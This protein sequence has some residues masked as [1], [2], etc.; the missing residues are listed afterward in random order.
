ML[1]TILRLMTYTK[2]IILRI[3]FLS[4]LAFLL[5]PLAWAQDPTQI[6]EWQQLADKNEKDGNLNEAAKYIN[7]LAYGFWDKKQYTQSLEF[8]QKSLEMNEKIG[9]KNSLSAING[10]IGMI[11]SDLKEYK[12]A[13]SYFEKSLDIRKQMKDRTGEVSQL[14]NIGMTLQYLKEY[15]ASNERIENALQLAKEL[16]NTGLMKNCYG[17]LAENYDKLGNTTKSFEY[18]NYFTALEK[19]SQKEE[20][21]KTQEEMNKIKS[22][23]QQSEQL[24]LMEEKALDEQNKKLAEEE[25]VLKKEEEVLKRT[26]EATHQKDETISQLNQDNRSKE[27]SIQEKDAEIETEKMT[28]YLSFACLLLLA[29]FGFVSYRNY[30]AKTLANKQL[31]EQAEEIKAKSVELEKAFEEIKGQNFKIHSS[32]NYA[33]RIQEAMLPKEQDLRTPFQDSFILFK[34]RDYVSGDFYWFGSEPSSQE[35]IVAACDCTGHGVPGAFMSMIGYNL[36]NEIYQRGVRSTNRL[37]EELHVGVR[38]ALNQHSNE[39]RDGMDVAVCKYNKSTNT[40]TYAGAKNSVYYIKNNQLEE[41]KG[42]VNPIGGVQKEE[43]RVF[44][45]HTIAIDQPTCVYLFSDGYPDQ[46]GG[47][48]G[49]KFMYKKLKELLLQI[50][51][52]PMQEQKQILL[53]TMDQWQA[54]KHKQIDDMLIIGFKVA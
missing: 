17:I 34:P 9:N 49:R 36:L 41:I 37:L 53:A 31:S 27:V 51:L 2:H 39:N 52:K 23:T 24:R 50:H 1:Y 54:N 26:E 30:K 21:K 5:K 25:K 29:A 40:V 42:D 18:F 11:Y 20:I 13:L 8:F 15:A 38:N 28:I 4:L 35:F 10:N 16:N 46:F 33:Q 6:Q 12:T 7:K 14:I 44:T 45:E 19:Q 32:I 22:Q 3:I 47:E 43:K 48:D